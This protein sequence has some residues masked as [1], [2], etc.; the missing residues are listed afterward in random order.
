MTQIRLD[1]LSVAYLN[2]DIPV[3]EPEVYE[4]FLKMIPRR[5]LKNL[6]PIDQ[7][8]TSKTPAPPPTYQEIDVELEIDDEFG[9][10]NLE[11]IE[12]LG[13]E[14]EEAEAGDYDSQ[15]EL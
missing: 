15:E 3:S 4:E 2:R 10:L 11:D 7:P 8:T 13:V 5:F 9:M 14:D 12:F 1:D 6:I